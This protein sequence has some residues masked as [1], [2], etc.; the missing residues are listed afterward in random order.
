MQ[1]FIEPYMLTGGG[2]NDA[3][4]TVLL[5]L[6]RYAFVVQRLRSG[7]RDE[8]AALR[9]ARPCSPPAYLRLTRSKG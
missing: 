6:Y 8:R 7:Q 5:L 1:V 9:G 2:P 4:V 3:T